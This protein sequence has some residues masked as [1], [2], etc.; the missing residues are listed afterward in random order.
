VFAVVDIET[1]GSQPPAD[2]ITEIAIVL[3][4]GASIVGRYHSLVNPE[5]SIPPMVTQLTGITQAMVAD[6]PRF[7]QIAKDVVEF[8]DGQIF[9]AHNVNFDYAFLRAA[10]SELGYIFQRQTLDTVK[11]SRQL[12]PGLPSYSL[13][14]LCASLGIPI[15]NRHR[16]DGDAEATAKLLDF[17]LRGQRL[18]GGSPDAPSELPE[19]IL[20][21]INS[22]TKRSPLPPHLDQAV[23]DRLPHATGVYWFHDSAGNVLYVGKSINIH[24]RILSHLQ[25][26][27]K[28]R[29]GLE[30]KAQLADITCEETGSEL[31][32]LLYELDQIKTL[33]P[34][35]NRMGRMRGAHYGIFLRQNEQ[36]YYVMYAR[37]HSGQRTVSAKHGEL[38]MIA[39]HAKRAHSYLEG[40]ARRHGLCRKLLGLEKGNGPCFDV[41]THNPNGCQGACLGT[42]SVEAY[43]ARVSKAL[44]RMRY[45]SLTFAI[46]GRGRSAD[47]RSLVWIEDGLYRGYGFLPADSAITSAEQARE[48]ITR[49]EETRDARAIICGYLLSQH[50]DQVVVL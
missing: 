38:I 42:E 47:E 36:G 35:Y 29:H 23:V 21:L 12:V 4:N 41:Q 14:R 19:S 34:P 7:Y 2:R 9:V 13:G 37:A 44:E 39:E 1:T 8:T 25:V 49:R 45:P 33:R 15:V 31:I 28:K 22:E 48:L 32:A 30:L 6:A 10:F 17:L 24:T 5:R 43:N 20:H 27:L 50:A 11:L 46:V 40:R 26:D 18:D 3:Y 16:A